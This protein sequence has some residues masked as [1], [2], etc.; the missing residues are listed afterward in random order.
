MKKS[1]LILFNLF[2]FTGLILL[3]LIWYY[4]G[5]PGKSSEYRVFTIPEKQPDFDYVRTLK[6]Q[7]LIKNPAGFTFLKNKLAPGLVVKPGGYRL[8][9]NMFAW[10][11]LDKI[12]SRQD[13]MWFTVTGCPRKEQIGE[14]LQKLFGWPDKI[15]KDWN[16]LYSD[17]KTENYEGVYYPDTYL[18]PVSETAAQTARRFIDKFNEKFAPL[19]D[20]YLAANIRWTTGIK[21][22]S[23]IAREAAGVTDM[24]LI[25]GIIWN[26]LNTGMPLQI[27][28]TLQYT[29][30]KNPDGSWWGSVD[31]SEKRSD[32]AYNTYLYKGLPPTPICSPGISYVEAALNPDTTTCLYYLHDREGLIHCANTYAQH[33]KNIQKYLF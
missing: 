5:P 33:K 1:A 29:H 17:I 9:Q 14:K 32:S 28:A 15:L 22:A 19:A 2:I 10:E 7:G 18:L 13:L 6:D 11:V 8:K 31:L 4:F 20:K 3:G 25:S 12:G 27:D 26:R 23:L 30:G 16:T 24:H 21:I